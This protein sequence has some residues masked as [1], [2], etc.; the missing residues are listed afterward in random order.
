MDM[1]SIASGSS[2]NCICIGN[3]RNHVMIDAGVSGKKIEEGMNQNGYTTADMDAVLITHEHIDHIKGLGVIARKYGLPIYA[4]KGTID[5]IR[6]GNRIGN[7]DPA[8][9]HPIEADRRFKIGELTVDPVG[10]SHDAAD[11]VA[12][13][14]SDQK[15]RA[16]VLTDLGTYDDRIVRAFQNLNAI[17]IEANHDI[18]MLECGP[19]PYELKMRILSDYGHLS[20]ETSGQL[21]SALLNDDME[22]I[23]L[24]H[25][26]KENNMP[27]LATRTVSLEVSLAE[28]EY[29][30][31]DF[32]ID[33]APRECATELVEL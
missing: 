6:A 19:Y 11:P 12:Y 28:N 20:N 10:I 21:L 22:Q 33:A 8:L 25:L 17:L 29:R 2:G 1:F 27:E 15:K 3:S 26:S 9:F 4:T 30:G 7:V 31:S 24:G 32:P 23:F 13:V 18:R 5:A 14:I 16:G